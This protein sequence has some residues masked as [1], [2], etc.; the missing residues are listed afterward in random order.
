MEI[1]IDQEAIDLAAKK[2]IQ[3]A[4]KKALS[5]HQIEQ[6]L[7]SEISQCMTSASW[8]KSIQEAANQIDMSYITK[9]ISEEMQRVS[10]SACVEMIR[11]SFSEVIY[12]MKYNERYADENTK[13]RRIE[14]ILKGIG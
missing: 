4:I 3:D 10:V 11:L 12:K 8:G 5:S 13:K 1:K 7:S 6:K 14:E 9:S 2:T